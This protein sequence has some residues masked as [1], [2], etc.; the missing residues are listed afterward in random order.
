MSSTRT[1]WTV[2]VGVVAALSWCAVWFARSRTEF[3]SP[4]TALIINAEAQKNPLTSFSA[5]RIALGDFRWPSK[6]DWLRGHGF[7]D[8]AVVAGELERLRSFYRGNEAKVARDCAKHFGVDGEN[9]YQPAQ[10]NLGCLGWKLAVSV[11]PKHLEKEIASVDLKAAKL[12]SVSQDSVKQSQKISYK[13]WSEIVKVSY[14]GSYKGSGVTFSFK[15]LAD[16][17]KIYRAAQQRQQQCSE[18]SARAALRGAIEEFL[19]TREAWTM[20]ES[21]YR[22]TAPCLAPNH[23]AYEAMHLR[24]GL[25]NLERSEFR[26][27]TQA[28]Y[29]ASRA[30]KPTDETRVMFWL[31]FLYALNSYEGDGKFSAHK[32]PWWERLQSSQPL[33][34]HSVASRH[35]LGNDAA[36]IIQGTSAPTLAVY[37]GNTWNARNYWAFLFVLA[38]AIG[39]ND[40][41]KNLTE[42]QSVSLRTVDF[43]DALFYAVAQREANAKRASIRSVQSGIRSFGMEHM[44][45]GVLSLLFPLHY[46]NEINAIETCRDPA[47]V[48]SVIR[49]ESYFEQTAGSSRGAQGL[50]QLLPSVARQRLGKQKVDLT[51]STENIRAG[52]T[53]FDALM[54]DFGNDTLMALA[55]FNAGSVPVRKWQNR[56]DKRSLLLF[57]DLIPFQ[58]TRHFVAN[59]FA[60]DYWYG[61]LLNAV[62]DRKIRNSVGL[63]VGL[64]PI[65]DDFGV[66]S[67]L[68]LEVPSPN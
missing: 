15:E 64:V 24:M 54:S 9:I 7:Q 22:S 61:T 32:N 14:K 46:L 58:E 38:E 49:Q 68:S 37:Q 51:N 65:P 13:T 53:H 23:P 3:P 27:A 41:K 11:R 62:T 1:L 43:E 26:K 40:M 5:R 50:M 8:N 52:C 44:S 4:D 25:L 2:S 42:V 12:N 36:K 47:L 60:G 55:S 30:E 48:L 10:E 28:L 20:I 6:E 16:V 17:R 56:F 63:P 33:S 45:K 29:L 18:G 31:G 66:S 19:P 57:V 59:V 34:L 67:S 35:L 21:L 39:D